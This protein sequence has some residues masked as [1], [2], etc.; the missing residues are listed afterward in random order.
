MEE[1]MRSFFVKGSLVLAL[2]AAFGMPN[3]SA[4]PLVA[5]E[6]TVAVVDGNHAAIVGANGLLN[7]FIQNHPNAG[8]AEIAFDADGGQIKYDV[9]GFDETGKY[10]L[11]Y[12][13]ATNQI[14]E[15]RE[16]DFHKSLKKK[17]FDPREILPPAAV[18]NFAYAQTKGKAV[19]LNEWAVR[20]DKGK[21]VY[22]VSF[23]TED[24]KEVHVRMDAMNGKLLS[25][26]FD[27]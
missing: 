2:A 10:E 6:P 1:P 11:T 21:I 12:I 3:A 5:V 17:S 8:I 20:Y 27:D 13:Y 7:A 15:K 24:N 19:S 18:V 22:K 16:G 4:A 23:G 14:F 26:K 25:V 9:E